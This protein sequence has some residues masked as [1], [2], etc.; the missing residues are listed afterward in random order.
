MYTIEIT[1][2]ELAEVDNV[3]TLLANFMVLVNVLLP[4]ASCV[5]AKVMFC[6]DTILVMAFRVILPVAV[7]V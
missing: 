2:V 4:V 6:P 7:M 5:M 3:R 1:S